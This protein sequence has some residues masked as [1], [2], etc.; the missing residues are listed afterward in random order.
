MLDIYDVDLEVAF[1]AGV[2]IVGGAVAIGAMTQRR[3]G[4]L[5]V[6]G[7]LL[8]A[9]FGVAAATPVSISSG[10]G[11]KTER[12]LSV[13]EL[14]PSYE[15]GVGSLDL[16]LRAVALPAGTTSVDASVG[17]GELVITVPEGVALEVDAHA[18]VGEIDVVGESDDGIDVD[19]TLTLAGSTSGCAA[20]PTRGRRG[21]RQHRGPARLSSPSYRL[22]LALPRLRRAEGEGALA[23]VCAGIAKSLR[24]D[25]TLVRLTFAMLAFAGGAGI[26]AYG[27]AWLA[28][29]PENGPAPSPRRRLVGFLALA[30]AGAIT[31]RGFGFSDSLIWPAALCGAGILLARGRSGARLAVGLSLAAVGVIIFVDQNATSN[32]GDAAFESSAVAIALVLVLGPWAWRLAADRDSERT[33]RIRSQE[34]AEMAARV[35]DSV[36]QTLALV[37]R[38][39]GDPRRVAA[40]ARRQERE[41]RSWLYPDPRGA[42]GAGLA[43]AMD[44]A[45]AEVEELHGV[46]VELV[47]TGDVPVDDRVEALVLAAREAMSNA[48]KHSGADQISAFVDVGDDEIAI[49]VRD[50]GSGFDPEVVPEG[51]HGIAES[52]RGRMTRAGGTATITSSADGTEVELHLGRQT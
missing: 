15:L 27:G 52:I 12:P 29:A 22:P 9:A 6:L 40:L 28:L 1:A 48:A 43:S 5:V 39:A 18:G 49:Y 34:R 41:L 47:R 51:A 31:L 32:G 8:L 38:E 17:A 42:D 2:V 11:E 36:L 45:A 25:P 3:V 26:A 16:D 50:R 20:A 21:L 14:Q 4:G 13:D 24:V 7:L 46:P 33:A 30:I 44:A 10:A 19:Q 23:G 37:Q 35:H